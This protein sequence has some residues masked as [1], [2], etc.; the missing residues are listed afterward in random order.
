MLGHGL[1]P[2]LAPGLAYGHQYYAVVQEAYLYKPSQAEAEARYKKEELE[3]N[4]KAE[5]AGGNPMDAM[6][7]PKPEWE[8]NWTQQDE[9]DAIER[10]RQTVMWKLWKPDQVEALMVKVRQVPRL[11]PRLAP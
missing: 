9:E 6:F 4:A 11:E 10:L 1:P 3:R 5:A 8:V 2:P 7:D